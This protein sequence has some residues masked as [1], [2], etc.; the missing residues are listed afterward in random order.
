MRAPLIRIVSGVAIASA[1][2]FTMAGAAGAATAPAAK[3]AKQH[4]TLSIV[5]QRSTIVRGKKDW[6]GGTL[7]AGRK[8]AAK[9]VVFLDRVDGR[10]L[11][12]LRVELTSRTGWVSFTVEPKVTTKYELVFR[13]TKKLAASHSGVVTTVVKR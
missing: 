6:V 13:G 10:K 4:T 2:V 3:A 1:A 8:A 12:P 9:E 5:E 7:R 11:I